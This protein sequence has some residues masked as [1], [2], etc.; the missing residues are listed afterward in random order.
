[1]ITSEMKDQILNEMVKHGVDL[2]FNSNELSEDLNIPYEYFNIIIDQF[3]NNG[4]M[5]VERCIGGHMFVLLT[6]EA[7]DLVRLGGFTAKEE[8]LKLNLQKLQLEID[9]LKET[10]PE[11]AERI[12]AILA[13]IAAVA[14]FFFKQ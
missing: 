12:T 6:A 3:E 5:R 9:S 4:L 13:N 1:M 10:S 7:F 14:S 8:I 2:E 11:K